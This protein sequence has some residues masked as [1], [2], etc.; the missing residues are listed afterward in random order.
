MKCENYKGKL[1]KYYVVSIHNGDS[2]GSYH[3]DHHHHH[4]DHDEVVST[5][6]INSCM[7][8]KKGSPYNYDGLFSFKGWRWEKISTQS[9]ECL[10]QLHKVIV[11]VDSSPHQVQCNVM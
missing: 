7:G 3:H 9:G 5:P 6:T 1:Q 4:H 2:I 10:D 8:N 11:E